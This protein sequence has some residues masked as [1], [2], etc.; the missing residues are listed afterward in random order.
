MTG[1][2][3]RYVQERG[4]DVELAYYAPYRWAPELSVPFWKLPFNSPKSRRSIALGGIPAYEIGTRLPEFEFARCFPS[5]IWKSITAQFDCH[6]AVSGSVHAAL[7][8]VLQNK[9]C[10]AWVA[11]PYVPDKID[12]VK[13]YPWYRRIVDTIVDTPICRALERKG[14]ER[15]DVLALSSYTASQLRGISPRSHITRMSMPIDQSEFSPRSSEVVVGRIGFSG[16]LSDPRKNIQLLLNAL[17]LCNAR[18][19][20]L[21]A[22]FVGGDEDSRTST[23]IKQNNLTE[24]V[25]FLGFQERS[26]LK[27]FY[28][29]LD[30]FVIPSF[31]EGLGIVGLEAMACGCPVVSTRCGGVEDYVRD[32]ITG[33]LVDFSPE[34]MADAIC[35]IV[36]DRTMREKMALAAA[37]VVTSEYGRERMQNIFWT[38]F[39]QTFS[40]AN[41][42]I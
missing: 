41:K 26:S 8:I 17:L 14:L 5:S 39:D 33:F 21:T 9:P 24:S 27:S 23:F 16:R 4:Y 42:R 28:R 37:Q 10:L 35:R 12:R 13:H 34:Q 29:S 20:N 15:S 31:Q 1:Q 40:E 30:V 25:R 3:A 32:G 19:S 11:T 6:L 2:I 38:A 22:H 36:A 18:G 7:P